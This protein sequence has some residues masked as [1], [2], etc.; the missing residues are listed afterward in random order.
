MTSTTVHTWAGDLWSMQ[1][2]TVAIIQSRSCGIIFPLSWY[3]EK[4]KYISSHCDVHFGLE[5][6]ILL[7]LS[8]F[9]GHLEHEKREREKDTEKHECNTL[10]ILDIIT[11]WFLVWSTINTQIFSLKCHLKVKTLVLFPSNWHNF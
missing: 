4:Q 9:N 5:F 7:F 8:T 11:I 3:L 2:P 10:L 1:I 6:N